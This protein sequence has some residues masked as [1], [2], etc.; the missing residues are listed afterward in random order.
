[1]PGKL[2]RYIFYEM[3][4]NFLVCS[5]FFLGLILIGR[6]LQLSQELVKLGVTLKDAGLLFAYMSPMFLLI[7]L[8]MAAMVAIFLTFLRLASDRELVALK[9][10]G[11]SLYQLLPAT[12]V[13]AALCTGLTFYISISGVSWGMNSFKSTLLEIVQ[14][15]ARVNVQPGVFNQDIFGLTLFARKVDPETGHMQQVIFEDTKLGNSQ[16]TAPEKMTR[17]TFL[18]PEGDIITDESRGEL[19]FKLKN[20]QIYRFS[21]DQ[22]SVLRFAEYSIRLSLGALFS[23]GLAAGETRPKEMSWHEL[24][25]IRDN[26]PEHKFYNKCMVEIQKRLTLPVACLV[27]GIF[28]LPLACSFEGTRQQFGLLIALLMF[29]T[30]YGLLSFAMSLGESGKVNPA[31][32][33]WVPNILFFVAGMA[34]IHLAAHERTLNL[35]KLNKDAILRL[36]T[37]RRQK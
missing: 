15:R 8:P 25:D 28:S 36:V 13:F 14:T 16:D 3:A 37:G 7:V 6:G 20:G 5:F 17:T 10:G 4:R 1:M 22:L 2:Q 12:L 19:V 23:D 31:I 24:L 34:G 21:D 32:G 35:P 33:M 30:Y 26:Q 18:A 11:V 9:S 27:L 29:L